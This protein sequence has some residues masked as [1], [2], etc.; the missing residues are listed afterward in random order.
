MKKLITIISLFILLL[1]TSCGKTTED[2]NNDVNTDNGSQIEQNLDQDNLDA[3]QQDLD[4]DI[5]NGETTEDAATGSLSEKELLDDID[6]DIDAL[7]NDIINS[8]ES[9]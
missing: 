4:A 6:A 7:L 5:N 9:E 3:D 8:A 1:L 2:Q